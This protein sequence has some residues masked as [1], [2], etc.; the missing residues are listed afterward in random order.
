M[1]GRFEEMVLMALLYIK[2]PATIAQ[3]RDALADHEM[4]RTFGSIYTIL[5]RMIGKKLVS[6]RKGEP[7]L[8]R[9][10]RAKYLYKITS[11]GRVAINEAQKARALWSRTAMTRRAVSH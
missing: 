10:G 11:G 8:Q 1:L 9:G 5:D 4:P 3:I 6:R 2:G 7:T